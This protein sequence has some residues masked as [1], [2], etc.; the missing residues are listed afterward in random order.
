MLLDGSG[1]KET[2][3][4]FAS[5][6]HQNTRPDKPVVYS[7]TELVLY[8]TPVVSAATLQQAIVYVKGLKN[9]PAQTRVQLL[10]WLTSALDPRSRESLGY[11]EELREQQQNRGGGVPEGWWTIGGFVLVLLVV[12]TVAMILLIYGIHDIIPSQ[13][14]VTLAPTTTTTTTAVP[15]TMTTTTTALTT[16]LT[17]TTTTTPPT[18]TTTATT[19]TGTF[20]KGC[21]EGATFLE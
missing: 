4:V 20:Q 6:L 16:T 8:A 1:G 19:T 10:F 7:N 21:A 9:I 3:T 2:H 14:V 15:T 13:G 12:V 5:I 11:G 18:T 17:T